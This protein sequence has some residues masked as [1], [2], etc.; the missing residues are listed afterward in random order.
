MLLMMVSHIYVIQINANIVLSVAGSVLRY[1]RRSDFR[2][3]EKHDI[4]SITGDDKP[5]SRKPETKHE[6]GFQKKMRRQSMH[7]P[8]YNR[9]E[10]HIKVTSKLT[11]D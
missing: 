3:S 5:I 4:L 6:G 10:K 1:N 7:Y 8:S 9:P 11:T 2:K